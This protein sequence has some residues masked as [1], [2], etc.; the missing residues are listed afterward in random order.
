MS[1][2]CHRC[3]RAL[4]S[5]VWSRRIHWVK[6]LGVAGKIPVCREC[7]GIVEENKKLPKEARAFP[8]AG[9]G[10]YATCPACTGNA[11][12]LN[13]LGH[14]TC[15]SCG[16]YVL[17]KVWRAKRLSEPDGTLDK[18]AKAARLEL[19]AKSKNPNSKTIVTEAKPGLKLE[20]G[21]TYRRASGG[22]LKIVRKYD[23]PDQKEGEDTGVHY[24]GADCC[25]YIENGKYGR[26]DY[27]N[28]MSMDLIA[29]VE[30]EAKSKFE[31]RV[32]G[33]YQCN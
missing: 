20:V 25:Y 33:K 12:Y 5:A 3:G 30:P 31:L 23:A 14:G 7:E 6:K 10:F 16:T 8:L 15:K 24:E 2:L 26:C 17:G 11:V 4:G 21:K 32:G 27:D 13:N 19:K 22:E 28:P 9:G 29:E 18:N 1:V